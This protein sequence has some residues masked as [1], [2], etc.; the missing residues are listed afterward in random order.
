M[1]KPKVNP[2][3]KA[4][5]YTVVSHPTAQV[6]KFGISAKIG[7]GSYRGGMLYTFTQNQPPLPPV[8]LKVYH[9]HIFVTYP[10]NEHL[11]LVGDLIDAR[12]EVG[13]HAGE[14]LPID[15]DTAGSEAQ[16]VLLAAVPQYRVQI[17]AVHVQPLDTLQI[18]PFCRRWY[19]TSVMTMT[20]TVTATMTMFLFSGIAVHRI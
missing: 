9:T 2:T 15:D 20:I 1:P 6:G 8:S 17:H 10:E 4:Y 19:L 13:G 14:L 11:A 5:A 12:P 18:L 16:K 7:V 3:M